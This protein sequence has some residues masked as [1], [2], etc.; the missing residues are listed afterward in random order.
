MKL[1]HWLVLFTLVSKWLCAQERTVGVFVNSPGTADGYTL[2]TPDKGTYLIDN[3]GR[4]INS[5]ESQYAAGLSAYL[6]PGGRLLRPGAIRSAFEGNGIGG[7]LEI[8]D[9]EG[10]LE[11]TYDYASPDFHQHHDIEP[12]PNG[13]ILVIAWERKTREEALAAGRN[14]ALLGPDE[15]WLEHIVEVEPLA[16]DSGRVVWRWHVWD[17]L[18]QDFDDNKGNFGPVSMHPERID[19]NY[20]GRGGFGANKDWMHFNGI[21]YN[22]ERDEILISSRIFNEF[23]IIDHSTTIEEAAGNAGGR[24]GKGGGLLYRWGNP[25]TYRRGSEADRQLFFQHDAQWIPKGYLNEGAI[26][27]FNNGDGRSAGQPY[28]AVHRIVPPVDSMGGYIIAEEAPYD[29]TSPSWTYTASPPNSFYAPIMSGAHQQKNG[30][31]LICEADNGRFFEVEPNG[32]TVWEYLNP[33]GL[34][35]PVKQGD[36]A[37]FRSIFR[38][39]KY[40]VEDPAFEGKH[41]TP[42]PLIELDPILDSCALGSEVA[43]AIDDYQWNVHFR[44]TGNPIVNELLIDNEQRIQVQIQVMDTAGQKMDALKSADH[45]IV[46]NSQNWPP[47]LY[48]IFIY[49]QYRNLILTERIIKAN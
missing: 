1:M 38:A 31:V 36:G 17:H 41:I 27:V 42:G 14:P 40:A 11:W 30:N 8:F 23:F 24:S 43:T 2:F 10:N 9:W 6:L 25:E 48:F 4:L 49:D 7:R 13:H 3:C 19:F 20:V 35:G 26:T 5:W 12:M 18:I 44:I 47:G 22:E 16:N 34:L 33:V 29:P 45:S 21:D 28:S 32:E 39:T 15:I 37:G 46:M